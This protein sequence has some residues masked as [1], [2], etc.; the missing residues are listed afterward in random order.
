MFNNPDQIEPAQEAANTVLD[1]TIAVP[2]PKWALTRDMSLAGDDGKTEIA[3]LH[4]D[5]HGR[6]H[7]RY[8]VNDARRAFIQKLSNLESPDGSHLTQDQVIDLAIDTLIRS[9]LN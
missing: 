8:A 2:V 9:M 5:K 1:D 6:S 3:N 4:H 7:M